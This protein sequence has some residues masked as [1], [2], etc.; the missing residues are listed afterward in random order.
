MHKKNIFTH[1]LFKQKNTALF[2]IIAR[3]QEQRGERG[4]MVQ[5]RI[6]DLPESTRDR[7][8]PLFVSPVNPERGIYPQQPLFFE[9]HSNRFSRLD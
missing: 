1:V 8:H 4:P 2:V 5:L 7:P 9:V 6:R 3:K